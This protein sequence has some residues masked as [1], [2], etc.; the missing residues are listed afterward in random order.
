[1]ISVTQCK[2][3]AVCRIAK[4]LAFSRPGSIRHRTSALD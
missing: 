1:M 4:G 3:R 2:R